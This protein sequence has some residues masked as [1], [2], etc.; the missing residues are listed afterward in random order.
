MLFL[1]KNEKESSERFTDMSRLETRVLEIQL[2]IFSRDPPPLL[3][4]IQVTQISLSAPF[5]VT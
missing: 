5:F 1:L 3:K 4:R 2:G